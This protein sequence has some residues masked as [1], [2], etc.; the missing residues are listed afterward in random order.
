VNLLASTP[1]VTG[2]YRWWQ[3]T[4]GVPIRS[5]VGY[6]RFWRHGRL[7]HAKEITPYGIFGKGL[8]HDEG[9]RRYLARLDHYADAILTDLAALARQHPGQALCVLCFEDV[10]SGQVCHRRWFAEWFEDCFDLV[11][12][13]LTAPRADYDKVVGVQQRQLRLKT[14]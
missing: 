11:V 5:T 10:T 1:L 8:A 13:E 3:P 9:R 7:W 4:D 2:R 12:A 6:P 14:N